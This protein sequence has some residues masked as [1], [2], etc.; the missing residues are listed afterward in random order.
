M[1][2]AWQPN[3][4]DL[5]RIIEVKDP[6]PSGKKEVAHEKVIRGAGTDPKTGTFADALTASLDPTSDRAQ[7][8][9]CSTAKA[10]APKEEA[11][12]PKEQA[13]VHK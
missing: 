6:D 2:T 3:V 4:S 11:T 8:L 1:P 5:F 12:K 9:P 7:A 13:P 10:P